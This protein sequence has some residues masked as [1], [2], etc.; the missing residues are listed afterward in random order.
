ML[1]IDFGSARDNDLQPR[2]LYGRIG[3]GLQET[4]ATLSIATLVKCVNDKDKSV[5]R[6]A[7]K[8][9]DEIKEERAFHR[10]RSKFWVVAKVFCY[11]GSKRGEVYGEFIDKSREDVYGLAQIRVVPLAEKSPSKEFCL[12][13]ACAD[14]MG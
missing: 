2:S 12:V 6:V 8:G 14:R 1:D 13:K 10:L 7:R 11:N 5:L 9:S 4:R 3:Q